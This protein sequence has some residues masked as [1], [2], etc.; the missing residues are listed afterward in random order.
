MA[1]SCEATRSSLHPGIPTWLHSLLPPFARSVIPRILPINAGRAGL[2]SA[3]PFKAT[4]SLYPRGPRS[5]PGSVVPVH[6]RLLGPIRPTRGHIATSPQAAYTRCLRCAGA[7]RRPASGS[8]LSPVT[9]SR[10]VVVRDPGK[11]AGCIRPVPSPAT[12]VFTHGGR[13]R[14]FR[15]RAISGLPTRSLALRPAELLAS[16]T[17]LV[18]PGFRRVGHPSRRRI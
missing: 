9:P 10:H 14:H 15:Y 6:Q 17:R 8:V 3:P 7:P 11:P 13:A 5:G 12:L 18:L 16:I 1:P 2:A 4:M